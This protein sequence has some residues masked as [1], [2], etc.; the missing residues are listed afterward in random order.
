M[1]PE[2]DTFSFTMRYLDN[3]GIQANPV[4]NY[5]AEL[6]SYNVDLRANGTMLESLHCIKITLFARINGVRKP[7]RHPNQTYT[8]IGVCH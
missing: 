7:C 5:E 6:L 2:E 4:L 1:A 3:C 8:V